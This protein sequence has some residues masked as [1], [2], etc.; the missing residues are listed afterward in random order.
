MKIGWA[1]R[2]YTPVRPALIQGQMHIRIGRDAVDPLTLTALAIEGG[3]PPVQAI[4]ISVDL[5]MISQGL[6]VAVR[7]RIRARLPD[8]PADAVIMNATHT[9]DA[10][11][12]ED[13]FYPQPEGD[14]M[15]AP[16]AMVWI[17]ERAADAAIEA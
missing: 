14:I 1:T 2:D 8:M 11:V 4:L 15:T 3:S 10:P 12:I 5:A 13:G 17:A 9:H 16:E 7:E 6:L